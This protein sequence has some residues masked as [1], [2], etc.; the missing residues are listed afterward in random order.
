MIWF[1]ILSVALTERR[2]LVVVTTLPPDQLQ[3]AKKNHQTSIES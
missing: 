1:F 2:P 3:Q